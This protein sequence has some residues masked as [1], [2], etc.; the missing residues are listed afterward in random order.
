MVLVRTFESVSNTAQMGNCNEAP[1]G[2]LLSGVFDPTSST[3][4][5][6]TVM[7]VAD[8]LTHVNDYTLMKHISNKIS[9]S[10]YFFKVLL[11]LH[12]K[13]M[14]VYL[15]NVDLQG[16][17]NYIS[18][19][20]NQ[21]I[22][23]ESIL[24]FKSYVI[25]ALDKFIISHNLRYLILLDKEAE[26]SGS[27][28]YNF[29]YYDLNEFEV[30]DFIFSLFKEI[31]RPMFDD[32]NLYLPQ[33]TQSVVAQYMPMF[34]MPKTFNTIQLEHVHLKPAPFSVWIKDKLYSTDIISS[35]RKC[36]LFSLHSPMFNQNL[37]QDPV[38]D[39]SE[40]KLSF[41]P[42]D[43]VLVSNQVF[44]FQTLET[45][46]GPYTIIRKVSNGKY[47]IDLPFSWVTNEI[48]DIYLQI[49][50]YEQNTLPKII[51]PVVHDTHNHILHRTK[52][53]SR[54]TKKII[55]PNN[56][57]IRMPLQQIKIS[58]LE[59]FENSR[60]NYICKNRNMKTGEMCMKEFSRTYDL[61]R[62]QNTIHAPKR[63]FYRCIFCQDDYR[64]INNLVTCNPLIDDCR[65]RDSRNSLENYKNFVNLHS[66]KQAQKL[67]NKTFGRSDAL[68]RHLCF[69]HGLSSAQLN[70]VMQ[71]AKENVEYYDNV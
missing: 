30:P 31:A 27:N 3:I 41:V 16:F 5:E 28:A 32:F 9:D 45:F 39:S 65:Y 53:V 23:N 13:D 44:G 25:Y 47:Q 36:V 58:Q 22:E 1:G 49:P 17:N 67:N 62:H 50:S 29:A 64:R 69:R 21:F 38:I 11:K 59:N 33:I 42:G 71:Y 14:N 70:R 34:N 6:R 68:M 63:V 15:Y 37:R 35:Y 18:D 10:N 54:I 55:V 48:T 66:T 52:P 60:Q 4:N 56:N 19:F 8:G 46:L 51:A 26:K 43:L 24:D 57:H 40:N 12:T 2:S 20:A 7:E 61:I